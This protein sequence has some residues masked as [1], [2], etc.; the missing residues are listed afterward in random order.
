M[1]TH[2]VC[3]F[4]GRFRPFHAGHLLIVK[5]ALKRAQFAY[6][7]VGSINEPINF[8]NPFTFAEVREMIRASL[9][10]DEADRLYVLGVV[11]LL[12]SFR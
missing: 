8:R 5:E 11:W 3:V 9:T 12:P 2:D 6:V 4:A 10:P 7:I 1:Y